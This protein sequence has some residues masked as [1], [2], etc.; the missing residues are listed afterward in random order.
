M[1]MQYVPERQR[2]ARTMFLIHMKTVLEKALP[3]S[4]ILEHGI[5]W[6]DTCLVR[7]MSQEIH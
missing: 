5:L 2:K 3:L 7:F 1:S 6:D 4:L